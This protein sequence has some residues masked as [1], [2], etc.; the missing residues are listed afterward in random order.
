MK[1]ETPL[2]DRRSIV[3]G[4]VALGAA[5]TVLRPRG[6]RAIT[7][8]DIFPIVDTAQGRL[9]GLAAGGVKMFKGVRYGG[10][11]SGANRFM[12]PTPAPK[13]SGVRDAYE[14]G[15][16]APQM[17]NSRANAYGGLIMFDIQPG[18]MGEDCL[19]LNVWTPTL[20]RAA[21]RPVL[22]HIHGGG[23]YG[24][25]GNSAGYDG[26]ELARFGDCVMVTINHR[27]GAF[28]YLNLANQGAAFAHSGAVGMMDIVAALGWVRE[29][30]DGF[31]GDPSRVLAF[32]QSGGGAKTSILMSMPSAK[33]LFHRAG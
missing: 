29:N 31:G 11:T 25:S 14:Y 32:G 17:P 28:G 15:Q 24:G 8:G 33:G 16:V 12:P 13:W 22:V 6:A 2:I 5:V 3:A 27:L 10:D 9:R 23:F 1:W 30:I 21:R 20:D 7:E 19:V 4:A 26:E 18:G